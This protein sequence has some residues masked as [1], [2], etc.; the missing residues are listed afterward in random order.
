MRGK[1]YDLDAISRR[2]TGF[3]VRVP[4]PIAGDSDYYYHIKESCALDRFQ[5]ARRKYADASMC[6]LPR[7]KVDG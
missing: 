1:V 2:R 5:V 4:R 6:K 3:L 7:V